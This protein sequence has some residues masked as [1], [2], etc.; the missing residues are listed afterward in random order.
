MILVDYSPVLISC[1]H[2]AV[3]SLKKG[4]VPDTTSVSEIH[5]FRMLNTLRMVNVAYRKKY[6]AMVICVDRKPYW[7][8]SVFPNY[9][10]NRKP[11]DRS[12]DWSSFFDNGEDILEACKNA[13][14][15]KVVDCSGVEADDAIGVIVHANPNDQ[16]MIISPDGDYKQLQIHKG[17]RQYDVIRRKDVVEKD[18]ESW[19]RLKIIT[20]DKKDGIP[21]IVSD[22]NT[23]MTE[24]ARQKSITNENKKK[25]SSCGDPLFFC[26][27]EMLERYQFNQ[28]MLDMSKVP[29]EHASKILE[30]MKIPAKKSGNLYSYFASKGITRWIDQLGDFKNDG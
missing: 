15:W 7:R 30:E 3:S 26:N 23:F 10:R 12:M 21:N 6:G 18:P 11:M 13:F 2:S 16:H 14:G 5:H 27:Q 19:L 17:V 22:V 4:Q 8:E 9:K 25:W 20:G 29:D 1:A 28:L 24:G